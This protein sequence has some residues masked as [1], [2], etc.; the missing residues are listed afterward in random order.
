M[1][2]SN[3]SG[4]GTYEKTCSSG[5]CPCATHTYVCPKCKGKGVI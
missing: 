1:K 4:R 3:C 5:H 2:F